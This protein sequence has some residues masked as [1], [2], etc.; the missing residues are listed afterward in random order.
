VAHSSFAL[1]PP[2]SLPLFIFSI[3]LL[4]FFPSLVKMELKPSEALRR[5]S[6]GWWRD[7]GEWG[8][9]RVFGGAPEEEAEA[10]GREKR[11]ASRNSTLPLT[12][13]TLSS[14]L[15]SPS[16]FKT[17]PRSSLPLCVHPHILPPFPRQTLVLKGNPLSASPANL[18]LTTTHISYAKS[19]AK[20]VILFSPS[21]SLAFAGRMKCM[22]EYTGKRYQESYYS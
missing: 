12:P 8:G 20:D 16:S 11:R 5:S 7:E 6:Q 18:E 2:V 10:W 15:L 19:C 14:V 17:L 13:Y 4:P 3:S 1:L 9:A 22:K 21:V